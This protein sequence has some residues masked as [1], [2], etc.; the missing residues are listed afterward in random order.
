MIEKIEFKIKVL[1]NN[2]AHIFQ[3]FVCKSDKYLTLEE[4]AED[5]ICGKTPSTKN[6]EYWGSDIPFITIPDMHN[7]IYTT[8]Y[9]RRLSNAGASTQSNKMLPKNSICVSCIATPGLVTLTSEESQTN[10]QINSIICKDN[11]SPY[12]VFLYLKQ[13]EIK[14]TIIQLGSG[15]STTYN[16]NKNDF[17][18][19]KIKVINDYNMLSFHKSISPLFDLINNLYKEI[20]VLNKVK[21]LYLKKFFG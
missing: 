2:A 6:S 9:E 16:L 19:I 21:Q 8:R 12:Y 18:K 11:I 4:C 5:I 1:Y 15:G 13:D 7:S 17:S 20:N 14:N 10:Q 3:K